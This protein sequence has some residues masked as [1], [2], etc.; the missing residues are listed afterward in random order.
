AA[1]IEM[2][3][4]RRVR[5]DRRAPAGE[6]VAAERRAVVIEVEDAYA[7]VAAANEQEAAVRVDLRNAVLVAAVG[8]P[9]GDDLVLHEVHHRD[10][11][12]RVRVD[13]P[14]DVVDADALDAAGDLDRRHRNRHRAAALRKSEHVE[15]RRPGPRDPDL[16]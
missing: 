6:G 9:R 13:A 11:T 5:E 2:P 10:A 16:V 3:E 7:A 12:V 15:A 14:A 8:L 1:Q 4:A